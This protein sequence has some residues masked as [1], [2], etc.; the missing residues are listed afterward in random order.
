MQL[1]VHKKGTT[2][3]PSIGSVNAFD[4]K[5]RK[6]VMSKL[7]VQNGEHSGTGTQRMSSRKAKESL[8]EKF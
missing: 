1:T 2:T 4:A 6:S 8:A 5:K 7:S 3:D